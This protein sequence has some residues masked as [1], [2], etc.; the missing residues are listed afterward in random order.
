VGNPMSLAKINNKSFTANLYLDGRPVVLNQQR[1]QQVLRD[2]RITLGEKLEAEVGLTSLRTSSFITLADHEDDDPLVLKFVPQGDYYAVHLVHPGAFDGAQ[3]FI[4]DKT[5]NLLASTSAPQHYFSI[6]TY[7]APKASLND[8]ASGAALIELNSEPQD[9]PLY[10]QL[11]D[12]M[13]LFLDTDP[14]V[15]GHNA[16][17]SKPARLVIKVVK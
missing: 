5:H 8:I 13:S 4:E 2:K 14:N 12:G 6:S 7:G 16:F 15:T 3:I 1:L 11:S 17:N 10:R 9:K